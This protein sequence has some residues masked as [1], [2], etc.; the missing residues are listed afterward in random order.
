V[1]TINQPSSRDVTVILSC[2][3]RPHLLQ[4][5]LRALRQ[6]SR[7]P[8]AIWLWA[9]FCVENADVDFGQV[10]VDRLFRNSTNAGVYG[11][12][13]AA[14][15][16]PTSYVFVLDD[17][18]VPGAGYLENA[19]LAEQEHPGIIAA[20]GVVLRSNSYLPHDRFGWFERTPH[21]Q[22]VDL[23]CN[24][25]LC[26]RETCHLMWRESPLNWC[27][28]EDIHLS[29]TAK[30]YAGIRTFVPAQAT[31]EVSASIGRFGA[32]SVALHR[33]DGHYAARTKLVQEYVRRGWPLL[34]KPSGASGGAVD[35]DEI[36]TA[37]SCLENQPAHAASEA[38]ETARLRAAG[39]SVRSRRSSSEGGSAPAKRRARERVGES[40]G[41]SPSVETGVIECADESAPARR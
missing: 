7:P 3:K 19:L 25:W 9:D 17:D 37:I 12:F 35:R 41:H 8:A 26:R 2:W 32:D 6:Q 10:E 4:T 15:L 40:E 30:K 21:V 5:Q 14:L 13:T 34:R 24:G 1:T 16:A 27:N 22:E 38:R 29:Y 23:G 36:S 39:A 20:A 31:L 28:G 33:M 18:M 11:R